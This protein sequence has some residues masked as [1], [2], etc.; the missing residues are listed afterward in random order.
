MNVFNRF[1]LSLAIFLIVWSFSPLF[2]KYGQLL[3][4]KTKR[5]SEKEHEEEDDDLE[6]TTLQKMGQKFQA[7]K[8]ALSDEKVLFERI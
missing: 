2:Y 7:L 3:V 5:I 1:C 6:A 4:S 8:S